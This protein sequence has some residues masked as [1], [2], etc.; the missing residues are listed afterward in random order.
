M[1]GYGDQ[2]SSAAVVQIMSKVPINRVL[3][4][5][6]ITSASI[7]PDAVEELI[8]DALLPYSTT[9]Q[10][11]S[12]ISTALSPYSTTVQMTSAIT[13][14]LVPYSTTSQMNT[15]I[16]TAV[17]TASV[18]PGVYLRTAAATLTTGY[19]RNGSSTYLV[20]AGASPAAGQVGFQRAGVGIYN[21]AFGTGVGLPNLNN[22]AYQVLLNGNNGAIYMAA[23]APGA[24]TA[25]TI[26]V[27]NQTGSLADP[28]GDTTWS[29]MCFGLPA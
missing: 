8:D 25:G 17:S 4:A 29:L 26:Y 22:N 19:G 28:S 13:A 3:L 2:L 24:S 1:A 14:A 20:I 9:A 15:A 11:A 10:V 23:F 7:T 21:I 27:L 6:A 12:T 16:A 5:S 18:P